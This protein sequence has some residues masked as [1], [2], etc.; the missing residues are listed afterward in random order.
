MLTLPQIIERS[1]QPY[2]AVRRRVTVPFGHEVD[3]AFSELKRWLSIGRIETAGAAFFKYDLVAMPDLE[4]EFGFPTKERVAGGEGVMSGVL[5]AG[6][7]ASIR[8]QGPYSNLMEVNAVLIGW[9]EHKKLR[10]DVRST[11]AGDAFACRLEIYETDPSQEPDPNQ[12]WTTVAIRLA[13]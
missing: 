10:W 9:A 6:K 2:V 4:I 8:Y 7:Y 12:W 13:G 1:D 11:A 3:G 5:P